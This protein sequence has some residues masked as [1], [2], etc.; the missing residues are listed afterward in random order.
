MGTVSDLL[1]GTPIPRMINVRQE[2]ERP[3]I[4]VEKIP[5]IV[6]EQLMQ[7]SIRVKIR[8]G[9]R[10]AITAGS[11]GVS[12]IAMITKAVVD[13][14]KELGASPFI[15]PAMGS[16]GGATAQGQRTI[17]EGFGITEEAMG[18]PILASMETEKIGYTEEGHEVQIDKNAN[19]ADGI[20]VL[21]REN[22]I[23]LSAAR[24][25]VV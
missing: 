21:N 14:V 9:M 20:L 7:E 6:H 13:T 23:R 3:R 15:V 18:C 2:F 19:Q 11:R 24:T 22:R 4:D 12:N 10:I 16:H 5:A 8:P 1:R 17:I 25:K